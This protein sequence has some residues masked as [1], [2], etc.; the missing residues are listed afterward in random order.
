MIFF[1]KDALE[2]YAVLFVIAWF[3]LPK[4][5]IQNRN[6]LVIAGLSGILALVINVVSLTFGSDHDGLRC[7][8]TG[9]IPNWSPTVA[10]HRFQATILREALVSYFIYFDDTE[11]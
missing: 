2:L 10:M 4:K 11:R 8:C 7:Y 1:A 5:D 9:P 3:T 6:A